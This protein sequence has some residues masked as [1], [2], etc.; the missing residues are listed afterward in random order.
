MLGLH[1]YEP[2][3]KAL[4]SMCVYGHVGK[5]GPCKGNK[6]LE[7]GDL[8]TIARMRA[9]KVKGIAS[10]PPEDMLRIERVLTKPTQIIE[11]HDLRARLRSVVGISPDE[12]QIVDR[13]MSKPT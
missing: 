13:A 2:A 11:R 8:L 5:C 12:V 10:L 7:R 4:G 1:L 9:S 3:R 6:A